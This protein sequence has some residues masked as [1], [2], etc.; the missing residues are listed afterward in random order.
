MLDVGRLWQRS[1]Q[2]GSRWTYGRTDRQSAQGRGWGGVISP[3]P[4]CTP[5][6]QHRYKRKDNGRGMKDSKRS[7]VRREGEETFWPRVHG[8]D[9]AASHAQSLG[10]WDGEV[11]GGGVVPAPLQTGQ[12]GCWIRGVSNQT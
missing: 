7:D 10:L 2:S 6:A 1:S 5:P 11:R 8:P 3:R 9:G 4:C 12:E